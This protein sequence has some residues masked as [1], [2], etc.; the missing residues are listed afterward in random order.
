MTPSSNKIAD[1]QSKLHSIKKR[2]GK[3]GSGSE[4][5]KQ[6][7]G[8][9]ATGGGQRNQ[10]EKLNTSFSAMNNSISKKW[11]EIN[12]KKKEEQKTGSKIGGGMSN[13]M[14]GQAKGAFGQGS[15]GAN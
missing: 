14:G 9:G 11:N 2:F 7:I 6:T 8:S 15:S 3:E 5:V 4:S 10:V 13:T 1:Y 12:N